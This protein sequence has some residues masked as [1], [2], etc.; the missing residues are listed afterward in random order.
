[1]SE[2]KPA[3]VE[4]E[5]ERPLVRRIIEETSRFALIQTFASILGWGA[6]VGLARL[7]DRRDFGV[8]GIA[9]FYIGLGNL[10]G[11]GGLGATLLRRKGG[12]NPEEYQS[13]VTAMLSIAG[14][15]ALALFVFAPWIGRA[16]EFSPAEVDVLRAMSPLYF[17]GALRLTP[18]VRLERELAF[19]AI[20]RIELAAAVT[21]HVVALTIAGVFGSVWALVMSQLSSAVV[22]LL[23]AY[24]ASPG[25]AGLG[26]SWRVFRPLF[27][28]GSKVQGLALFAYFKDN[29]SRA[30]LGTTAGPSA[31]GTYDF[32]VG[33]IQVPV[34]AV[35]SLARVQLPVY[36]R[37]E[38]DDP[39]LFSALRGAMRIALLAGIPLIAM[40]AFGGPW[41]VSLIYG[42]KWLPSLPIAW[43]LVLNMVCGLVTS[44]L[45]T[46]LQGQGRA[47]LALIAFGLWTLGTW[48]LSFLMLAI[49][50]SQLALIGAAQSIATLVIT[51]FLLNWAS[52]HLQRRLMPE[53]ASPV[54][55]GLAAFGTGVI[56]ARFGHGPLAHPVA[57]AFESLGV[58][59]LVLLGI[60]GR[61]VKGEARA[62]L[63]NMLGS[64]GAKKS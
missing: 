4:A 57:V 23:L 31:V 37:L 19:S 1:M 56:A 12:V 35:N 18:Y 16:N 20:A 64:K 22:Q 53:L 28:Y 27:A 10:L 40:L 54:L 52:R 2:E 24:R 25:W 50:S 13:T 42:Q 17:V 58:Y 7:L 55:A 36:A 11:S 45:F 62:L 30:L 8:F 47:G 48:L 34:V 15:F 29:V 63:Q 5:A 3:S 21:K 39:D 49:D 51:I 14:G 61:T 38:R 32:A 59:L 26:F 6:N 44:P 9:T 33:Y 43:A 60:D 41:L 46:L